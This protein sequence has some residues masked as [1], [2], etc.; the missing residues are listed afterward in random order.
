MSAL[1]QN[2]PP[3]PE[4]DC[5]LTR[6]CVNPVT[7]VHRDPQMPLWTVELIIFGMAVLVALVIYRLLLVRRG[8]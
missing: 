2:S 6:M 4:S 7:P 5:G 8:H 1:E 3:K